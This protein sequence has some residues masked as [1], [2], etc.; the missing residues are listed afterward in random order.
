MSPNYGELLI[1]LIQVMIY[2]AN[3][4]KC[5]RFIY[6][7]Q[8]NVCKQNVLRILVEWASIWSSVVQICQRKGSFQCQQLQP[9]IAHW[10]RKRALFKREPLMHY[11]NISLSLNFTGL[12]C[13]SERQFRFLAIDPVDVPYFIKLGLKDLKNSNDS[14]DY[15]IDP[16]AFIID[17]EVST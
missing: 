10:Q 8:L 14:G 17:S 16:M 1:K 5:V 15:D 2:K 11:E 7:L 12:S 4:N 9:N 3:K 13:I 6:F